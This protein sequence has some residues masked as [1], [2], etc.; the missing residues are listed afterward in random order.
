M[1]ASAHHLI[2]HGSIVLLYGLLCGA[3]YARAINRSAP[4]HVVHSWRVAH[5]SLPMGATLMLVVAVLLPVL[6]D[7]AALQWTIAL[8]LIVSSYA[9]VVALTLA[10]IVGHRG[11]SSQGPVAGR[12][13][14]AGNLIG[15]WASMVAAVALVGASYLAL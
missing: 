1:N 7:I 3:P 14:F 4:A 15:A 12:L 5:A 10:P 11:L 2:F 9:F 6:P 13:V 8:A